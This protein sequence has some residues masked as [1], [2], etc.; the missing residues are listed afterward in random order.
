MKHIQ[1]L[2]TVTVALSAYN[3]EKN[4][5]NF[6]KS[7]LKQN[8]NNF[9]IDKI[10]V[11]SDG[12]DDKTEEVIESLKSKRI[13]VVSD[14]D[15][16]G[17]SS[18]LNQIYQS[19]SSDFLVQS[20]ADV[21]FSHPNVIE[22]LIKPLIDD[23]S[24]GMCGGNPCPT[25]GKT[26]I[27]RAVNCTFSAYLDLRKTV[28]G[29]NNVFSV[30]GRLL[31]FRKSLVKKIK[32]PSTMI[33][34]DRYTYFCCLR[35]KFTY[36]FVESAVV[37]FKSPNNLTDQIRQ[38]TRF[39][40]AKIRMTNFFPE[41]L[42]K[43]EQSIPFNKLLITYSKQFFTHPIMCLFIFFVNRY[44]QIAAIFKERKMTAKWSIAVSTKILK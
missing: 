17:K 44:C 39:L 23:N 34:N 6:L 37:L 38:N 30:D 43:K 16:L 11:Y 4:I 31:A 41:A 12:S 32:V 40:A 36:K 25:E 10:V 28:R 21:I 2:P 24:V 5:L 3:E 14:K 33:A 18:R 15:R 9:R 19:L 42:V 35:E 27:E 7:V 13:F 22:N 26:F 29:G 1:E 20:D 8:E